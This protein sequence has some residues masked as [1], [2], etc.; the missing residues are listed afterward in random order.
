MQD[1][2]LCK[3]GA[4][5]G[6]DLLPLQFLCAAIG[7]ANI[8]PGIGS[9]ASAC[10]VMHECIASL[11]SHLGVTRWNS[12]CAQLSAFQ[13]QQNNSGGAGGGGGGGG[14]SRCSNNCSS[15]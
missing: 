9:R 14:G 15:S 1:H 5:L 12:L 6:T 3:A 10:E 2:Q 7:Y 8:C 11:L 4:G 13:K